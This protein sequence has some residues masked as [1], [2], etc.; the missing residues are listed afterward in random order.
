MQNKFI[1]DI[2]SVQVFDTDKKQKRQ[3]ILDISADSF[4]MSSNKI[5]QMLPIKVQYVPVCQT[6]YFY[7]LNIC[8]VGTYDIVR[9]IKLGC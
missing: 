5:G 1:L 4:W 3:N 2:F 6:I 9:E 7:T 8:E